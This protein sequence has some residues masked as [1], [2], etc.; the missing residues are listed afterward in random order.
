MA[1]REYIASIINGKDN[2]IAFMIGN[3]IH[4]QYKDCNKSWEELLK[5]LWKKYTNNDIEI[6]KG[7]SFTEFY[8]IIEMVAYQ[9]EQRERSINLLKKYTDKIQITT[10]S[11]G[12]LE[13]LTKNTHKEAIDINNLAKTLN[14]IK[15][16][17]Q[18]IDDSTKTSD[19]QCL[20]QSI[21]SLNDCISKAL[22][23]CV[24]QDVA[25]TFPA[26]NEY[27]LQGLIERIANLKAPILTTNFDTYMSDSI[28]AKL[29]KIENPLQY[30][31]NDFYPWNACFCKDELENPL[32][33]FGI[34]H[35]NGMTKYKRSI[36]LG[37]CDYMGCV[38]R[39]RKILQGKD[40]HNFFLNMDRISWK[41]ANTWLNILFNK[42]LFIFGLTL[43][44]N[45]VFLRWLLIQRT[46][47]G[48]MY[49]LNLKGW[50]ISDS[51]TQGKEFFLKN[52]GFEII[53]LSSYTELYGAF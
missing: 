9:R 11:D 49:N 29:H 3:G 31:F 24:K 8:D 20:Y 35:I 41:G 14:I 25:N 47:Y 2:N 42:N 52:L 33:G 39:A 23:K 22:K 4:Y 15:E 5:D 45:E 51:I 53:K 28:G 36:R 40:M 12:A 34:W 43:D 6:P 44:E 26:K 46:K 7:I 50:F 16:N 48:R 38:E 17:K 13:N 19:F 32:S 18:D 10:T 27:N 37:L 1:T 21:L 30:S